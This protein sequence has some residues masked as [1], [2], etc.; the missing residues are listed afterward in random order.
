[1]RCPRFYSRKT[2]ESLQLGR[3]CTTGDISGDSPASWCHHHQKKALPEAPVAPAAL[4]PPAP[5]TTTTTDIKTYSFVQQRIVSESQTCL[6]ADVLQAER[7]WPR[8]PKHL[9]IVTALISALPIG[10]IVVP[11]YGLYLRSYI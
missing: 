4:S 10:S 1:M 2:D 8:T 5:T 7:T 9:P 6:H 11:F 3:D